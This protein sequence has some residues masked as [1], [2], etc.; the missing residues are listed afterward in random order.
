[1]K[2]AEQ[3]MSYVIQTHQLCKTLSGRPVLQDVSLHVPQGKIYGF[4]GPNGAGKTTVMKLLT[5]LWKPTSGEIE[6]FG[7]RL[8]GTSY[9]TLRRM[10]S[11]IE[12]PAFYDRLT[13]RENL[14]L[15][16][17]YMGY[18]DLSSVD[19][20]LSLL[21]LTADAE[22]RVRSYSLGMR[23]RLGVAR[24]ILTKPEL[25]ILD[26]PTNGLDPTGM[27][28]IR[29][30]LRML[31]R[32][33]GTTILISSHLLSEVEHLA[34]V[35]GLI[36][37]GQ[38]LRELPLDEITE[39]QLSYIELVTPDIQRACTV[40]SDL[41]VQNF[42]RMGDH[43]LRIYDAPTA[44]EALSHALAME[45]VAIASFQKHAQTLED[46]YLKMTGEEH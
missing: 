40:L 29:D 4:L 22:R 44:P 9:N 36:H 43:A 42:K 37:H 25:L 20:A 8:T 11:I 41:N 46:Y 35:I 28:Q 33:Y 24:A 6:L 31:C 32:D 7:E 12:F 16:C 27:K 13:A 26:E 39:M 30:L 5:N 23:Q 15:H 17:A 10:G 3:Q 21:R 18:H 45:N 19:E 14:R 38:M 34:D 1:M 2:G